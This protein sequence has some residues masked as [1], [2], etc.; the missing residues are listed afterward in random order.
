MRLIAKC[1][2]VSVLACAM[3]LVTAGAQDRTNPVRI[4]VLTDMSGAY[5]QAV[6]PGSIIAAKLAISDF[7]GTVR[8]LP[9]EVISADMLNKVDVSTSLALEWIDVQHVD[10]IVDVPLSSATLAVNTVV[11]QRDRIL[12]SNAGTTDLSGKECNG[13]SVQWVWD[14]YAMAAALTNAL[15]AEHGAR[16]F[17]LTADY[18]FGQ[19]LETTSSEIVRRN[20]G[21]VLGA[22]RMP[23]GTADQSSAVLTAASAKADV[24]G[25]ANGGTDTQN[26]IKQLNEFGISN[27]TGYKVAA[28]VLGQG[29]IQASGLKLTQGLYVP[30]PFYWAMN[31]KTRAWSKRF[32]MLSGGVPPTYQQAGV[33]SEIT[34]YLKALAVAK[35]AGGHDVL[36]K[37]R[38]IPVHD[39]LFGD[40]TLRADGRVTFPMYLFQVKAP[41]ESE[42]PFDFF[43]VVRTVAADQALRPLS[44][45]ACA[46]AATN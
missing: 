22:I 32:M 27:T 26:S 41:E 33:Y 7:G 11:N 42:G 8:N 25:L 9:I 21:T 39:D 40:G 10:A 19:D 46:L 43:K 12:F 29:D 36:E 20:G 37:M 28:F 4:G 3:P 24:I 17:Y 35:S 5:K 23:L 34:H 44:A 6:G 15:M 14:N 1:L 16:W 31:D 30:M 18:T 13:H 2:A 38:E 45:T